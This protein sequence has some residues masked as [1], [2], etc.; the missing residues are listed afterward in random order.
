MDVPH[1]RSKM[2]KQ[3]DPGVPKKGAKIYRL[4]GGRPSLEREEGR[5]FDV[6]DSDFEAKE[7]G[8]LP[9]PYIKVL[10]ERILVTWSP[11]LVFMQD[12]APIHEARAMKKSFGDNAVEE[13]DD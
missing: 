8:L 3:Y 10:D 12:N 4:C 5:I 6:T 13:V 11:G 7:D 1:S 9:Q 2:A